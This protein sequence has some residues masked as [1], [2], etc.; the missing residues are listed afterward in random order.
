M[1]I[2]SAELAEV[3]AVFVDGYTGAL[4]ELRVPQH[5]TQEQNH[6]TFTGLEISVCKPSNSCAVA[7][8]V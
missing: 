3:A 1:P 2:E 7:R 4:D 6:V 5:A 8:R